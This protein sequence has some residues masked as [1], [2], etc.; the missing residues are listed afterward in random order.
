MKPHM[1]LACPALSLL[2]PKWRRVKT[3]QRLEDPS[4]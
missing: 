4:K 3:W 1:L 2:G